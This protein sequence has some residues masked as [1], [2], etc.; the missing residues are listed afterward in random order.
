[1]NARATPSADD[2]LAVAR[3]LVAQATDRLRTLATHPLTSAR[4]HDASLVTNADHEVDRLLREGLQA[5]FPGHAILTEEAGL[6]AA[7]GSRFVWMVD[8]LDG[9]RAYAKGVPGFSVMVGLLKDSA[10]YLGLVADPIGGCTYEAVKGQGC[11]L[12]DGR[13]QRRRLQVSGRNRWS[14]MPLVTST[15]FP[16][17]AA[18]AV[19]AR[20]DCPFLA[21]IH[22]VGIKVGLLVRQEA[23]IYLNHHLVS[24][25]DTCAPQVILEEAGGRFT[26]IDGTPLRYD[27]MTGGYVHPRSTLATNGTRHDELVALLAPLAD[28][29]RPAR[30]R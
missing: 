17:A 25:W 1:M 8:P 20:L 24:Y 7:A 9:T 15:G 3:R 12:T 29:L 2:L 28:R 19:R 4:K 27:D 22:S 6:R 11:Y 23:D 16:P 14:Q 26:L 30:R 5:A 13:G 10:P 21:P 18:E